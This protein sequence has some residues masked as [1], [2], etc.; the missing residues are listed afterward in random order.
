VDLFTS[1]FLP[2]YPHEARA[3]LER[4]RSTDANP[5]RNPRILAHIDEAAAVFAGLA[6]GL[7][8]VKLDLDFTDAS[9]HRL[10]AALT[11]ERCDA[12][13]ALGSPGTA[14]NTLFNVVVHGVAYVGTCIVRRHGGEWRVRRPLWESKVLL[15]SCAGEGELAI[16]H[17]WLKSLGGAGAMLADRY[18][19]HVEVPCRRPESLPVAFRPRHPLP[20]LAKPRY[21]A[22][23]RYI[24]SQLPELRDLGE[25]FPAPER[26]EAF[27]LRWL[28]FVVLGDGRMLLAHGRGAHGAHLFWLGPAGFEKA[29]FY[30]VDDGTAYEVALDG[31]KLR[32]TLRTSGRDVV[33]E[34]LWWGP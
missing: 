4:A 19:A 5:G 25:S 20:R 1:H 9:V 28:D 7:C 34:M 6:P 31:E 17:W 11:P 30:P 18:R 3:D 15:R 26:F 2:L 23:H 10:S 22:L 13:A 14:E 32:L 29:A 12:W 24:A 27:G 33:H 21:A 16:F 8:G